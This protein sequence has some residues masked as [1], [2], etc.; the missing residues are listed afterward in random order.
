MSDT[1]KERPVELS[2]VTLVYQDAAG[3][4]HEQ[5][6]ADITSAGTLIDPDTGEDLELVSVR[7]ADAPTASQPRLDLFEPSTTGQL[8]TWQIDAGEGRSP[9]QAAIQAWMRTFNC[10]A[11][12]PTNDEACVFTVFQGDRSVQID[13][14]DER[15]AELFDL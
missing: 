2:R 5:P 8:V 3:V 11:T 1:E 6:V 7:V 10:G 13:L 14:S 12:Q 4:I 15:F 9:A